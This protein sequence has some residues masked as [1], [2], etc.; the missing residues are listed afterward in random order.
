MALIAG[1]NQQTWQSIDT[2]AFASV[3]LIRENRLRATLFVNFRNPHA[4]SPEELGLIEGV[5]ARVWDSLE[6][7]RAEAT[8]RSSEARFRAAVSAVQGVLWTNNA[9]GEMDGEQ[10]GWEALTGQ[11]RQEYEGYGWS[12]VVHPDDAQPTLEAWRA[13]V[14]GR[15]PF[16]F[17]H[18]VRRRDGA[19]GFFSIRAIPILDDAGDIHEWVGVHT[20][21][22]EQR[23]AQADLRRSNAALQAG[24]QEERTLNERLTAQG[25][26]LSRAQ[27]SLSAIF[28]A[29]SEGLTLCRLIIDASGRGVDYQ[30]LDVNPAHRVLTG[31]SRE[32]MLSEPV[33]LIA[34]P[35]DPRW[36][37]TAERTVRSG[38]PQAFEIRSGATGRWLDI[39][40]SPVSGDLFAQTFIDVTSRHE[41]EE[42]R[43]RLLAE[44]NHRVMNNF[45]M[46]ASVLEM[47]AS[48]SESPRLRDQLRTAV[49][50]VQLLSELHL[51]LA[52]SPDSGE[53]DVQPF[54][55]AVCERLRATI[56]DPERIRLIATSCDA[57][58]DPGVAVPLGFVINE[59]VTNAIKYAFPAP[60]AG[61]INVV[62]EDL[63]GRGYRLTVADGGQGLPEV[64]ES[65]GTGLGMRLVR[66]FVAQIG[67]T[68]EVRH[69]NGVIYEICVPQPSAAIAAPAN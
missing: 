65:K 4:W 33:S 51:N 53:V 45:Q 50:R 43:I 60:A 59:L 12:N 11:T 38:Q 40:V 7:A 63:P 9:R 69:D 41:A 26:E 23:R 20:D 10:A 34:P 55:N 31:A 30:V 3:P 44:M 42:A 52:T 21:V 15:L 24:I 14:E 28:G 57:R 58:L 46:V 39:R 22:S 56:E 2:R 48:R 27:Q 62:F 61:E 13:A 67:G 25:E 17:E 18:R 66:G 64:V 68:L 29:S 16:V 37:E 6:R 1:L 35:I 19:W 5:G 8:L 36:I 54:F 49:R 32:Q 47:Q